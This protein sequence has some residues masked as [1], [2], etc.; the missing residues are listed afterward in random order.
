VHKRDKWR[1]S[2]ETPPT[3]GHNTNTKDRDEEVR[4]FFSADSASSTD[5]A[6]FTTKK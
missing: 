4:F 5:I 6:A 3:H 2:P 1:V